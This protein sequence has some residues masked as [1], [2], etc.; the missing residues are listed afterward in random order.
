[1]AI[2]ERDH[3]ATAQLERQHANKAELVVVDRDAPSW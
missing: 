3:E 1:M 2:A